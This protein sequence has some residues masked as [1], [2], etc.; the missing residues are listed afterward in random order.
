MSDRIRIGLALLAAWGLVLAA[1]VA[2]VLLV[3]ADIGEQ[4]RAALIRILGDRAPH[5]VVVSLLLVA[6]LAFVLRALFRLYV[7]APRKL[8]EDVRIMLV[9]NSAHRARPRGSKE[10]RRLAANVN[11]FAQ[12]REALQQDVDRR[13]R[14]ANARI[15]E[16]KNRLAALMSELAQSVVVCN[17]EG[18]I[19]LY[20]ARAMQLLRKPLDGRP[21]ARTWPQPGGAGTFDIRDLRPQPHHP[22]AGKHLASASAGTRRDRWQTSS[23]RRRPGSSS[24]CRWR[25]CRRRARGSAQDD[26]TGGITGFVLVLED[27]TRRIETGNR[28]DLLLQT[29]TQGTRASLGS[30]RAAVETIAAFPEMDKDAQSRFIGII[31]D[32]AKRLSAKLDQT[33][34]EFADSLRTEWPLEDMRGA[35]LIAAAQRRIESKL[36]LPTKTEAVDESIWLNVDSYSLLQGDDLPREPAARGVRRSGSPLRAGACRSAR[37]PGP[38]LDRRAAG[39]GNDDVVADRFDGPGWRSVPVDAEADRRTPQRGN[40]VPDPQAVAPRILP[41]RHSGDQP[42]GGCVERAGRG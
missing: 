24:A 32:E 31:G 36:G 18:R 15:E 12:A 42:G 23:Q 37:A 3:G 11:D 30:V 20:N 33:V 13:I 25:R 1:I 40:L 41:H 28:R 16:E 19:L 9:A 17:D 14:E 6:P 29:L 21:G 22:R 38:H 4:D 7:A 27:I 8:A 5:L 2:A 39:L 34:G 26:A 35:D 10:M